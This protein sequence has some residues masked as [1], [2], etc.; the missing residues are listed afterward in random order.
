MERP[1]KDRR[2]IGPFT[3]SGS[4]PTQHVLFLLDGDLTGVSSITRA[5]VADIMELTKVSGVT[6]DDINTEIRSDGNFTIIIQT[7]GPDVTERDIHDMK[8]VVMD[9][10][11]AGVEEVIVRATN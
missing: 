3:Q 1:L 6:E 10:T 7:G 8:N 2:P 11:K 4:Q 9:K 5:I